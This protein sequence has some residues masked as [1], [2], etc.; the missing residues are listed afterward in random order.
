MIFLLQQFAG[1][2]EKN[3]EILFSENN[4]GSLHQALRKG[5]GTNLKISNDGPFRAF[6]P[7]CLRTGPIWLISDLYEKQPAPGPLSL[8][9][10]PSSR[11]SGTPPLRSESSPGLMRD[12]CHRGMG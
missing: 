3:G 6:C 10:A 7:R 12:A 8:S 4:V 2:T 9:Q 5:E 11:D 1:K